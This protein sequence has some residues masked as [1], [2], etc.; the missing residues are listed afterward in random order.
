MGSLKAIVIQSY[1]GNSLLSLEDGCSKT[2]THL[3]S[4]FFCAFDDFCNKVFG[5]GLKYACTFNGIKIVF[6]KFNISS[7]GYARSIDFSS[8]FPVNAFFYW[9]G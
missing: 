9:K 5:G 7:E 6:D 2:D 1:S 8:D 3:I 4:S